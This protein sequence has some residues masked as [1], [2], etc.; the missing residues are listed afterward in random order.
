[1]KSV[2]KK[3]HGI[4]R[5]DGEILAVS[6]ESKRVED[7]LEQHEDRKFSALF[8][9]SFENGSFNTYFHGIP[10]LCVSNARVIREK[11]DRVV[12]GDMTLEDAGVNVV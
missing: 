9:C 3:I 4:V 11:L 10:S 1:M 6:T 12:C 7:I 8:S 2:S 5:S